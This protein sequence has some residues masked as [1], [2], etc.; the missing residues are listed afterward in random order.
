MNNM[1]TIL[2]VDDEIYAVEAIKEM[3]DWNAL[4]ID[5]V[6]TAYSMQQAQKLMT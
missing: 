4:G 3:I 2:I 6:L 5:T 1:M